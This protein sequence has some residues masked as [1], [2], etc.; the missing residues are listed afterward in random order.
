MQR[1][2]MNRTVTIWL[3]LLL[4]GLATYKATYNIQGTTDI[5]FYDESGYLES[6]FQLREQPVLDGFLYRAQYFLLH[7]VGFRATEA[8][9][10]QLGL[11]IL[12]A[13]L[14]VFLACLRSGYSP[15]LALSF[16][17]LT[18]L[19]G[20]LQN[21][22]PHITRLS[23]F[24]ICVFFAIP[25]SR[26]A[27]WRRSNVWLLFGAITLCYVRPEFLLTVFILAFLQIVY[28]PLKPR[29]WIALL[30]GTGLLSFFSPFSEGR[31]MVAF[32]QHYLY[33]KSVDGTFV[34]NPWLD[35]T[36]AFVSVF[37]S[38]NT[39]F[40]AF[41]ANP[42]AFLEHIFGNFGRFP[43]RAFGVLR[44]SGAATVML[45]CGFLLT[46]Y[47]ARI[48][49]IGRHRILAVS[50]FVFPSLFFSLLLY[51]RDHYLIQL[52][53]P[54]LFLLPLREQKRS[55]PME[56]TLL[57]FVGILVL[58]YALPWRDIPG[59]RE[60]GFFPPARNNIHDSGCTNLAT[61]KKLSEILKPSE[62]LLAP[63][64]TYHVY[65]PSKPWVD[66]LPAGATEPSSRDS[67]NARPDY[68]FMTGEQV[69]GLSDRVRDLKAM[70]FRGERIDACGALLFVQEP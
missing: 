51:P 18:M 8:Y 29:T 38:A 6:G 49:S 33:A 12:L 70:G 22:W 54:A 69:S 45:A 32:H 50:A 37:G 68:V 44:I 7:Y 48:R 63:N 57:Q 65:L 9:F 43:S 41:I 21:A 19:T 46:G 31:G 2:P 25:G 59:S 35:S 53:V 52:L 30:L 58:L 28:E 10:V 3:S 66:S 64:E 13:G 60:R 42:S 17:A 11:L 40:E 34:G 62:Y 47:R 56:G 67:Q 24:L 5:G 39:I 14:G 26:D 1:Y 15:F 61:L 27:S 23:V 16:A 20:G 55:R 4:L 36:G